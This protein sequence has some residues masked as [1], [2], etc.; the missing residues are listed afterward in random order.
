MNARTETRY[1]TAARELAALTRDPRV[2]TA[3]R[4]LAALRGAK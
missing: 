2:L 1:V 3:A 4:I